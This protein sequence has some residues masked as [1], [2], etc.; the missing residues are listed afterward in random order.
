MSAVTDGCD[1]PDS[2]GANWKHGG[3][4][5]Y[6]GAAVNATMNIEPLVV[7]QIWDK[8]KAD[9]Q[10][11]NDVNSKRYMDQTT[12]QA[13]IGDYCAQSHAHAGG[14]GEAGS[15]FTQIFNEGTPSRVEVTTE[16]PTGSRNYEIFQEEC[17]YYLSVLK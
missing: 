2:G 13:N 3:M 16:W 1:V 14:I 8:G 10:Q 15:H 12:A 9:G 6:Q 7:R 4:I 17:Q 5:G 11:C